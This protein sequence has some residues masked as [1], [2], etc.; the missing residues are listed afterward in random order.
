M[1]ERQHCLYKWML[2]LSQRPYFN[3][4]SLHYLV[5]LVPAEVIPGSKLLRP[6]HHKVDEVSAATKAA[7]DEEVSQDSE[8]PTQVDVL[9]FLVLLFIHNGLLISKQG[10]K[11][12]YNG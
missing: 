1:E 6:L 2:S 9:I 10:G 5:L 11:R 4:S 7:G 3:P 8:E 12:I